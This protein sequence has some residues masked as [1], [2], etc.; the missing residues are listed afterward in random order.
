M[1]NH[2]VNAKQILEQAKSRGKAM[3]ATRIISEAIFDAHN[4][5]DE[6]YP[7]KHRHVRSFGYTEGFP[8]SYLVAQE[9]GLV[10]DPDFVSV[11]EDEECPE[12]IPLIDFEDPELIDFMEDDR[13]IDPRYKAVYERVKP[14]YKEET[15]SLCIDTGN[16]EELE[17]VIGKL[18]EDQTVYFKDVSIGGSQGD[19]IFE[20]SLDKSGE[21]E[22]PILMYNLIGRFFVS[23][24]QKASVIGDIHTISPDCDLECLSLGDYMVYMDQFSDHDADFASYV[25]RAIDNDDEVICD[26]DSLYTNTYVGRVCTGEIGAGFV[27]KWRIIEVEERLKNTPAQDQIFDD[28]TDCLE[29]N[30]SMEIANHIV[31]KLAYQGLDKDDPYF[32]SSKVLHCDEDS[33]FD[34][35]ASL[36]L[37]ACLSELHR[38]GLYG[39]NGSRGLIDQNVDE[40]R[41]TQMKYHV[42]LNN[43]IK[44]K[45]EHSTT[46]KRYLMCNLDH[47]NDMDPDSRLGRAILG[48]HQ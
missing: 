16:A 19:L 7:G 17:E 26:F 23:G 34:E 15:E 33:L 2:D 10:E 13:F 5:H 8:F 18:L 30:F 6:E 11:L 21:E 42:M 44:R 48:T 43:F 45:Q 36:N 22:N 35:F 29:S 31:E 3:L 38:V 25:A 20:I 41:E 12:G 39:P 32:D 46:G 37:V 9:I 1:S 40:F 4:E 24:E 27:V 47:Q 28:M 14:I